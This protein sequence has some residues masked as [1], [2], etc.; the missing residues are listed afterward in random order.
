MY[1]KPF[2]LTKSEFREWTN[3]DNTMMK[4]VFDSDTK[5]WQLNKLL[6]NDNELR[7]ATA[8]LRANA[9]KLKDLFSALASTDERYPKLGYFAFVDFCKSVRIIEDAT[10]LYPKHLISNVD[11]IMI[12]RQESFRMPVEES[13]LTTEKTSRDSTAFHKDGITK[14][15][16]P[17]YSSFSQDQLGMCFA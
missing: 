15:R 13:N 9:K 11:W 3:D 4:M 6:K 14:N 10:E 7:A 1:W 16:K 8:V 12:T 2:V 17:Q 5:V